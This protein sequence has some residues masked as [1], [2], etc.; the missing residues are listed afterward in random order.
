MTNLKVYGKIFIINGWVVAQ[1][2]SLG[3]HQ[4]R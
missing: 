2:R 1:N 4:D 3:Y